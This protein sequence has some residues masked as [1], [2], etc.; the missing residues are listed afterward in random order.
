MAGPVHLLCFLLAT[1]AAGC[2]A[3]GGITAQETSRAG[4]QRLGQAGM[5]TASAAEP[6]ATALLPPP[7]ALLDALANAT[8]TYKGCWRAPRGA[9]AI[10]PLQRPAGVAVLHLAPAAGEPGLARQQQQQRRPGGPTPLRT[11]QQQQQLQQQQGRSGPEAGSGG[12]AGAQRDV[13]ELKGDLILRDGQYIAETDLAWRVQG[14]YVPGAAA[15]S[16][17]GGCCA[18]RQAAASRR[19]GGQ[20]QRPDPAPAPC[21]WPP[22]RRRVYPHPHPTPPQRRGGSSAWQSR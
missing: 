18:V 9:A 19:T 5:A 22:D 15:G 16:G 14:V 11:K 4:A 17:G 13:Q 3:G 7:R 6:T 12:D 1:M 21:G 8:G 20:S 2:S 10:P